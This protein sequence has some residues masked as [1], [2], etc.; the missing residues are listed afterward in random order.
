MNQKIWTLLLAISSVGACTSKKFD[1][2]Q[3]LGGK[4]VTAAHLNLGYDTYMNYCMQCHG[5]NGDGLGPAAPGLNPPPRNF[6]QGTFKF[7]SVT[8]GELPTDDDLKKVVRYGLRGTPML[9][10]DISDERLDAVIQYIKTFS[11]VWK[12]AAAGTPQTTTPDPWGAAKAAEAIAQGRKIYHGLAQCYTCHPGY[13]SLAEISAYSESISGNPV[14]TVREHPDLS[15]L[16]DSSYGH[17]FMPPDFTKSPIKTGGSIAE[18]YRV[19]G[20]G[21]G[22]TSMPTWKGMLS[23]KGDEAES[24]SNLWAVAYYVNSLYRL[25]FDWEKRKAF[26]AELNA[27]RANDGPL[28]V[29]ASKPSIQ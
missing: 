14:K 2:P 15:I 22:G 8:S 4:W 6:H 19:L 3:K 1:E 26:F 20:T 25:Q 5:V 21:V 9:P 11:P 16:Q 29:D 12:T 10:W 28:A 13:A 24:E 17:K 7:G 27:K 18:L 23:P